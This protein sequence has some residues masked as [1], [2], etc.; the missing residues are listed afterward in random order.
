[1]TSQYRISVWIVTGIVR[2]EEGGGGG[3]P[4]WYSLSK[5]TGLSLL[6]VSSKGL[7]TAGK[8]VIQEAYILK[9]KKKINK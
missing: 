4:L 5:V 6:T 7:E 8:K 9:K 3:T 2:L 1:M